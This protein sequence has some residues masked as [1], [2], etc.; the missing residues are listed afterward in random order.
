[1][2]RDTLQSLLLAVLLGVSGWTL[3]TVVDVKTE[4]AAVKATLTTH[5]QESQR[6]PSR[7]D[8]GGKAPGV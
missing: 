1:M 3:K 2:K 6:P 7:A 4:L 8:T 5:M